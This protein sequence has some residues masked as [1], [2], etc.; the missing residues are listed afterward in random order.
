MTARGIAAVLLGRP[1]ADTR[2]AALL[3]LLL[4]LLWHWLVVLT[5]IGVDAWHRH[6]DHLAPGTNTRYPAYTLAD[7]L[8]E[9]RYT[10]GIISPPQ[11]AAE[12][13]FGWIA[14][15]LLNRRAGVRVRMFVRCWWRACLWWTLVAGLDGTLLLHSPWLRGGPAIGGVVFN[16]IAMIVVP[17]LGLIFAPAF[18]ARDEL[19]PLRRRRWQ[20]QCPE[21]GYSV[22]RA[23]ENRCPECG[24]EYLTPRR[25]CRRWAIQR[26]VWDRR[27]RESLLAAYVWSAAMIL[28]C[29]CRAA[30]RLAIPDRFGRA[31]RWGAAHVLL[32]SLLGLVLGSYQYFP[33]YV[34]YRT[35]GIAY[36]LP[37]PYAGESVPAPW[38]ALWAVQSWLVWLCVLALMPGIGAL[39]A[40]AAPLLQPAARAGIVK[41]S[42]Y[43]TAAL[44]VALVAWAGYDV[45]RQM[46]AP[47]AG[48]LPTYLQRIPLL[49]LAEVYGLVWALGVAA[50]PYLR[51]RGLRVMLVSLCVYIG[52]CLLLGIVLFV[53]GSLLELL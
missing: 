38:V 31:A 42:L 21:C 26:L 49:V 8:E 47:P 40:A 27:Q 25:F 52:V 23:A 51:R 19:R 33:G 48:G 36:S 6:Q 45:W 5:W 46:P 22:F 2:L 44:P 18:L 4:I 16:P 50:N 11:V 14:F 1:A 39:L 20:P 32:A 34:L 53:A 15:R 24:H 30:W 13:A 35:L 12:A 9:S 7:A 37:Y 3:Q 28:L 17:T 43:A 29:P 41:W 10:A